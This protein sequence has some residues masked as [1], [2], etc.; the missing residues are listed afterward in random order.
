[1]NVVKQMEKWKFLR[2]KSE[3]ALYSVGQTGRLNGLAFIKK[4]IR[5]VRDGE[6][7]KGVRIRS[8]RYF[9]K[10]EST[11]FSYANMGSAAIEISMR[12]L[13]AL[14]KMLQGILKEEKD[15]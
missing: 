1:M 13:P 3:G 11:L 12:D 6:V 15:S 7:E 10:R 2:Y 5:V 8:V 14:I 4:D 9:P